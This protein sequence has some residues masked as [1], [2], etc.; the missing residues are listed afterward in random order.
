[1]T[2]NCLNIKGLIEKIHR[3]L[4]MNKLCNMEFLLHVKVHCIKQ[5]MT[6]KSPLENVSWLLPNY[7]YKSTGYSCPNAVF[8]LHILATNSL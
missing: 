1:M 5:K 8:Y 6:L 7:D 4:F 3:N 2:K